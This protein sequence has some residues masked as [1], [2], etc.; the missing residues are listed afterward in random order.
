MKNTKIF[1]VIVCCSLWGSG[2]FAQDTKFGVRLG[3]GIPD[4]ESRD[5]NIYA[6]GFNSVAGFDGGVF[7]DYG[8]Y[9][10]LL[11]KI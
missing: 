10:K 11:F 1:L 9:R 4:L 7:L 8:T 5:N 6:S 2:L 3:V